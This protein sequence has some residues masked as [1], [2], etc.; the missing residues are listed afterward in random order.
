MLLTH[1]SLKANISIASF[2]TH[3]SPTVADALASLA[4]LRSQLI[5]R[6]Y[7]CIHKRLDCLNVLV[8]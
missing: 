7:M 8:T 1:L 6:V 3:H 4:T 5:V 2:L